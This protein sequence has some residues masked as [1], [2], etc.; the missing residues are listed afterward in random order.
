MASSRPNK[1]KQEIVLVIWKDVI[2]TSGWEKE[3]DVQCPKL[4]SI[5][6]LISD[7]EETVKIATTLDH[8]GFAEENVSLPVPYGITAFP[9]DA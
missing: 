2:S 7:D 5:G 9:K 6:W 1:T 4:T 8:D 3:E